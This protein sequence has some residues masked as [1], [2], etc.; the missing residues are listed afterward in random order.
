MLGRACAFGSLWLAMVIVHESAAGAPTV[1][2]AQSEAA[3]PQRDG[4]TTIDPAQSAA[5]FVGVQRFSY[6][7]ALTEVRYAVDDAV[8]L[9]YAFALAPRVSLVEPQHVALALSGDPQKEASKEHLAELLKRGA[10]RYHAGQSDILALLEQQ[11]RAAGRNG[12]LIVSVATHGADSDNDVHLL[13]ETSLSQYDETLL[14]ANKLVRIAAKCTDAAE[15]L[16][17]FDACRVSDSRRAMPGV[18][19]PA[20]L[21]PVAKDG[22]GQLVLFAA[23][24]GSYAYADDSRGNG[25]F[26]AAIIDALG[27]YARTDSRGFVTAEILATFVDERVAEWL[28][29]HNGTSETH[30]IQINWGSASRTLPLAVCEDDKIAFMKRLIP[31]AAETLKRIATAVPGN[32]A[33]V[34]ASDL[35]GDGRK[36]WIVA[37]NQAGR[38]AGTVL[39]FDSNGNRLWNAETTL[40]VTRFA[41]GDLFRNGT[42]VIAAVGNDG[43]R[44]HLSEVTLLGD[45]G[46]VRGKC[47]T[48]GPLD[49]ITIGSQSPHD[50]LR[51]IAAGHD[52]DVLNV[53]IVDPQD[54]SGAQSWRGLLQGNDLEPLQIAITDC[55]DD[56][57]NE[58]DIETASGRHFYWSFAGE[59]IGSH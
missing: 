3:S 24:A 58:I 17:F 39:V 7:A 45:D 9:A 28:R 16:F 14:S 43:D 18:H 38:Q 12:V 46:H 51:I 2:A 25:V 10:A 40:P 57:T 27:C 54:P 33:W 36:E 50:A 55:D 19:S 15:S 32:V 23:N 30:A 29:K 21:L 22:R 13:P 5:L 52:G 59:L 8:D 56:G 34:E 35:R 37:A 20:P 47:S 42:R 26:S 49:V 31:V 41:T 1:R 6:D 48:S 4:K 53:C 11:A 44:G